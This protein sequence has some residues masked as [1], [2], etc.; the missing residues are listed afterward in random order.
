MMV[1][2]RSMVSSRC[3]SEKKREREKKVTREFDDT[4]LDLYSISRGETRELYVVDF[5]FSCGIGI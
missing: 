2:A 4:S 3:Q 1:H 5:F